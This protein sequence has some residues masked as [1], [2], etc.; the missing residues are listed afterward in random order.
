MVEWMDMYRNY[1]CTK[2][3]VTTVPVQPL[4][5]DALQWSNTRRKKTHVYNASET[6]LSA[7]QATKTTRI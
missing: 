4:T 1:L 6:A 3:A 7:I 5:Y 2:E